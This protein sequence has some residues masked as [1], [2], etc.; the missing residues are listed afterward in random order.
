M[1]ASKVICDYNISCNI[2]GIEIV[3]EFKC[4]EILEIYENF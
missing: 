2:K 4:D 1:F 3:Y